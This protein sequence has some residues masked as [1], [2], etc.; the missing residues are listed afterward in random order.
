MSAVGPSPFAD[1][2]PVDTQDQ[3]RYSASVDRAYDEVVADVKFA[4]ANHNFRITGG[5][6]IGGAIAERN[7]LDFP[8]SQIV[9][10][11]NLE[12][13][14]KIIELDPQFILHMPCKIIV[15]EAADSVIVETRLLPVSDGQ[16]DALL[17]QVNDILKSIVDE[18]TE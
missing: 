12:Y 5:N 11:C 17:E 7:E 18:V 3:N 2:H 9:H 13:A 4:I 6:N 1:S 14:K 10:F 16:S 8:A 15:R